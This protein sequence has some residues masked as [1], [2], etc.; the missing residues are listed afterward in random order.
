MTAEALSLS[1]ERQLAY[2][3]DEDES[4][5]ARVNRIC[6]KYIQD[7]QQVANPDAATLTHDL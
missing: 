6:D 4:L 2:A 1:P 3:T 7:R 5:W